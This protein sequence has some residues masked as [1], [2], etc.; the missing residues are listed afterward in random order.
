M[1]SRLA[2]RWPAAAPWSDFALVASLSP[3]FARLE[4]L[5]DPFALS[6]DKCSL[7]EVSARTASI[8]A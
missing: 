6:R 8:S 4:L 2:G 5:R 3:S 7:A 1:S